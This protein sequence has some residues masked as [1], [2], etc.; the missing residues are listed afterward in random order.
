[1]AAA[2]WCMVVH[3][4]AWCCMAVLMVVHGV[5]WRMVLHGVA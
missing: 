5:A 1:M 3:G 4:V 2:W